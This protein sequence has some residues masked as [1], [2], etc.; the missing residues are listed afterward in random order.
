MACA[1]SEGSGET[2]H[3]RS[4]GIAFAITPKRRDVDEG[5]GQ[6]LY[7]SSKKFGT[8][9]ICEPRIPKNEGI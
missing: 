4:L 3:S 5:L 1:S 2:A 7:A 9:R 6:V 8:N